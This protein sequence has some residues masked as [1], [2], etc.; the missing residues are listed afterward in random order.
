MNPNNED[1][2]ECFMFD[3][4]H[5]E[6]CFGEVKVRDERGENGEIWIYACEAHA[7]DATA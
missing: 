5:P 6:R 1:C 2:S 4:K 3:E 7:D